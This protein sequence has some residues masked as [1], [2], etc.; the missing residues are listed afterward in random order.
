MYLVYIV[1]LLKGRPNKSVC[2][3]HLQLGPPIYILF[4]QL[5]NENNAL[6]FSDIC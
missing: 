2:S 4:Q 1:Y 6:V 3:V 5:S